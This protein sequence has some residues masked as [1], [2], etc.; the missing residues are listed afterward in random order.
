MKIIL[1]FVFIIVSSFSFA[2]KSSILILIDPGHGG[3]DPGHLSSDENLKQEKELA[4]EISLKVGNYL[5]HNMTHVEVMYTRTGDTYPT[6]DE[7]VDMANDNN[8]DYMLSIH[9]N[10]NPN[11]SVYGTE[12][13]IHNYD[14]KDAHSWAKAIQGQ[15]KNRAGRKSRGV[16]TVADLGHSL[17]ILKFTK[18]PTILVECGFITNKTEGNYL[19]TVYGQEII[20]SAIFRGTRDFLEKKHPE[21]D[22]SPEEEI[23]AEIEDEPYYKV[24]IMSSIDSVSTDIPEFKKLKK[25]VERVLI[26]GKSIYKYK[27]YVGPF[28]SKK[29]AK[30]A[31]K[32]VQKKGFP[33]A[34]LVF[35]E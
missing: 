35:F 17:Q 29:D 30:K 20:A 25:P 27:Y 28:E 5:S 32:E 10:G 15:F 4:L 12:T 18:M 16:K 26:E 31:Q 2:E 13:H 19:N 9:I 23:V 21:I 11:T 7:R 14:A 33:D 1:G 22:F 8:V 3:T 6:L 34:F 24:Q